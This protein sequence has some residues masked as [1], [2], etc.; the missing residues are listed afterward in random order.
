MELSKIITSKTATGLTSG[1]DNNDDSIFDK[2]RKEDMY[3]TIAILPKRK[4]NEPIQNLTKQYSKY[5]PGFNPPLT[6][7]KLQE[8]YY[9]A[10][11][12]EKD[13][14][15]R[16]YTKKLLD[17]LT[18][19]I[20]EEIDISNISFDKIINGEEEYFKKLI[21][22]LL[23]SSFCEHVFLFFRLND[24]ELSEQQIQYINNEVH[25]KKEIDNSA[26]KLKTEL[27]N[28]HTKHIQEIEDL[29][30]KEVLTITQTLNQKN[31]LLKE[32]DKTIKLLE[33][34][35]DNEKKLNISISQ[36]NKVNEIENSKFKQDILI[37]NEDIK[38]LNKTIDDI[39]NELGE[40]KNTKYIISKNDMNSLTKQLI[41]QLDNDELRGK[42]FWFI[43]KECILNKMIEKDHE[44]RSVLYDE[45]NKKWK[46]EN[47]FKVK[48]S[49]EL[50]IQ[51]QELKNNIGFLT[52]QINE[53]KAEKVEVVAT[54]ESLQ[55]KVQNFV[56][57]LDEEIYNHLFNK[58]VLKPF[59]KTEKASQVIP[60][61]KQNA[62]V[63][64]SIQSKKDI[65]TVEIEQFVEN[66]ADNFENIGIAN[67]ISY[68]MSCLFIGCISSGL[69]PLI[70][71]NKTRNVANAISAAFAGCTPHLVTLPIGFTDA[72]EIIDQ[73]SM[74]SAKVVLFEDA[75]GGMN[76]NSL[77][78]LLREWTSK[79]NERIEKL[80]LISSENDDSIQYMPTN[81][82]NYCVVINTDEFEGV[83][84]AELNNSNAIVSLSRWIEN[85]NTD[86]KYLGKISTLTE[87]T[88][89]SK[90]Y[91]LQRADIISYMCDFLELDC[92]IALTT[93][94]KIELLPIVKSRKALS[95][96]ANNLRSLELDPRFKTL[97]DEELTNEQYSN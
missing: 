82:L 17:D 42:F 78:P 59:L 36:K 53:K 5:H 39:K 92:S 45:A 94:A 2:L 25:I 71:G 57:T 50:D 31:E 1:Q 9:K 48:N 10:I 47:E 77:L 75:V 32:K 40:L 14:N 12:K 34:S 74:S 66:L 85:C 15:L 11:C 87:N 35:L 67:E 84:N 88:G 16:K 86:K 73:Y 43:Q 63:K 76:E 79:G 3:E 51:L 58:A 56:E 62:Y 13:K 68:N 52:S 6:T 19:K 28:L 41:R 37:K 72:N 8:V 80:L 81:L 38:S 20:R 18:K 95:S 54:L 22:I 7:E 69:V 44:L 91:N 30:R 23:D 24:I 96:F 70:Y 49:K 83:N 29:H 21:S 64:I 89:L 90:F 46:E 65:P 60:T 61:T 26:I 55:N 4:L 33:E 93:I 97:I 27:S